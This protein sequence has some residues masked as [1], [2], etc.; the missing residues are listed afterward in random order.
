M[1]RME[2]PQI[3]E[4]KVREESTHVEGAEFQAKE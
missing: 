2:I 4:Q 3:V 1:D